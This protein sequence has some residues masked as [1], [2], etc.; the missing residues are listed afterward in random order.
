MLPASG[1]YSL[2][3]VFY[4]LI[5]GQPPWHDVEAVLAGR[6]PAIDTELL[7][8][9]APSTRVAGRIKCGAGYGTR[10]QEVTNLR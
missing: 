3:L 6:G 4:H 10:F 8:E 5:T 2:G 7:A 1:V 9:L